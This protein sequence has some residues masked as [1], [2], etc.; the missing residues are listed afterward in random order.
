MV[1]LPSVDSSLR[2]RTG[3]PA[4]IDQVRDT[5]RTNS[6]MLLPLADSGVSMCFLCNGFPDW[7]MAGATTCQVWVLDS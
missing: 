4:M 2:L 6:I 5:V 7:D 3:V 1:N